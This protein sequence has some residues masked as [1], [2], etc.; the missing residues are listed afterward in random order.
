[1]KNE[2]SYLKQEHSLEVD[3]LK[4][5]LKFEKVFAQFPV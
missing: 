3:K 2:I 5:D 1:M 4:K